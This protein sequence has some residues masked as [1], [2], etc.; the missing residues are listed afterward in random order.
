M[1]VPLAPFQPPALA[2][3]PARAARG[4]KRTM[5]VAV[6]SF[7]AALVVSGGALAWKTHSV[8][9]LRTVLAFTR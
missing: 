2:L 4:W 8:P 5:G 3:E 7:V 1:V 9:Q 6:L